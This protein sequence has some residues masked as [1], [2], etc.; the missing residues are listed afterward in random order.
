MLKHLNNFTDISLTVRFLTV[1][2]V[3]I[4][5]GLGLFGPIFAVFLAQR[6]ET[7]N[8]LEIIGI[9]TSIYLF[10]RSLG[11]IP[12]AYLIDKIPGERDDFKI[13]MIGNIVYVLVP[14][15]YIFISQ[16][17]H[18]FAIQFF[19]GLGAAL[20]FPSW[21]AIFTR[22]IDKGKEGMEWGMY[23]TVNDMGTAVAASIGGFVAAF[24]GFNAVMIAASALSAVGILFIYWIKDDLVDADPVDPKNI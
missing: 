9:G 23:Q 5:T 3:V 14:I 7:N 6:I 15:L 21:Y 18:L 24:Y 22:H 12:V 17:W 16:P 19:Y 13:L 20:V 8:A 4:G 2:D 1:S 11:Q 10:T